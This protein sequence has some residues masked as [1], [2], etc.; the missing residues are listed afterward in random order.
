MARL[1]F[2]THDININGQLHLTHWIFYN[3]RNQRKKNIQL[4]LGY[5]LFSSLLCVAQVI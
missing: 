2:H 1:Q 5:W 4:D 3:F